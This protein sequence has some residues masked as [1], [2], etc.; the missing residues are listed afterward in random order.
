MIDWV[1]VSLNVLWIVGLS[2]A[3]ATFS[4]ALFT[5]S[6][7]NKKMS[8]V[9]KLKRYSAFLNLGIILLC[10]G[11]CWLV[12]TWWE[13]LLLGVLALGAI[14]SLWVDTHKKATP[15]HG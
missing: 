12:D 7:Q 4:L 11:L 1:F 10:L 9:L 5:A 6:D 13:R 8:D 2:L 3:L 14:V 15:N